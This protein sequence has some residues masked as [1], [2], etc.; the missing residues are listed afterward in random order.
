MKHIAPSYHSSPWQ[1]TPCML[2]LD[3]SGSMATKIP[4][5]TTTRMDELNRGLKLLKTELCADDTASMRVQLAIVCVGGSS[6]NAE[7]IMDWTDAADFEPPELAAT[8]PTPL[9][10]GM[11]LALHHV[12]QQKRELNKHGIPYTRPWVMVI[13]DGEPSD[14]PNVWKGIVEE[15]RAAEAARRC[16]IFPIGVED[17][18]LGVLQ[19]L[20]STRA[21]RLSSTR[22]SEYF[23]WLSASLG[24]VSRSRTGDSVALPATDPW[25]YFP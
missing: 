15:C 1:R 8:G 21:A 19:E 25:T 16:V 14:D 6:H 2:V 7:L 23:Q 17:G 3:A 4:G 13:S 9:A 22:F 12:D 5:K 20:S 10:R 11:R 24:C 18:D